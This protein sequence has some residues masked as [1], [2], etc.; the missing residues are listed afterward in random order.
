M[1]DQQTLLEYLNVSNIW[2]IIERV[3]IR[4]EEKFKEDLTKQK[5]AHATNAEWPDDSASLADQENMQLAS[6]ADVPPTPQALWTPEHYDL[7]MSFINENQDA[8]NQNKEV[9]D[10]HVWAE[11]QYMQ[12]QWW[13]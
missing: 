11:E 1:I 3:K 13:Q 10:V 6:W 7:H 12:S 9:F 8:Y 2:D 4:Q 5:A